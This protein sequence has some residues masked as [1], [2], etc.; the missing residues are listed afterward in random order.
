M[1]V[2]F[3]LIIGC[4]HYMFHAAWVITAMLVS[5]PFG[6][7]SH[8]WPIPARISESCRTRS[9]L[10]ETFGTCV[11]CQTLWFE[12]VCPA[13]LLGP[14]PIIP[15]LMHCNDDAAGRHF[16][17]EHAKARSWIDDGRIV[18]ELQPS[19]REVLSWCNDLCSSQTVFVNGEPEQHTSHFYV[20]VT[21]TPIGRC[22]G[23]TSSLGHHIKGHFEF[24]PY[25]THSWEQMI[26]LYYA[27]GYDIAVIEK[28]LVERYQ[29]QISWA[30][31]VNIARGGGI[32]SSA[33]P[34]PHF[35][36]LLRR[37]DGFRAL[38]H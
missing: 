6:W 1:F 2:L 36:Y 3:W 24:D 34:K 29:R 12:C 16:K 20:G 22:A 35:L 14:A 30:T 7:P 9:L 4:C 38:W 27:T 19:M 18:F 8:R 33:K 37:Y 21:Q 11:R 15:P 10:G 13:P 31:C 5:K 25:A 23:M 26:V 32:A 17:R 28:Y